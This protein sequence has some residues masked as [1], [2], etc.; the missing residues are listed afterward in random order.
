[1]Q[2]QQV[3]LTAYVYEEAHCKEANR[4][5]NNYWY[6]YVGEMFDEMGLRPSEISLIDLEN[7]ETLSAYKYII[8]GD[9]NLN[10]QSKQVLQRWVAAGGVLLGFVT[11]DADDL[12]GIKRIRTLKQPDD[13]FTV[14]AYYRFNAIDGINPDPHYSYEGAKLPIISD[15]EI[16]EVEG[17]ESLGTLFDAVQKNLGCEAIVKRSIGLGKTYYFTFDL[18]QTLWT[19]HQGRPVVRDIDGDGYYR[20]GDSLALGR[21]ISLEVP[22]ADYWLQFIE[23]VLTEIPQP[24][25]HQLPPFADGSVPDMLLHYGG[26]DECTPGIQVKASNY[27]KNKGLGYH[28]NIMPDKEGKFAIS[29]EEYRA[30]QNN[31]HSLSLHYD[32]ATPHNHFT[33][34]D[35]REQLDQYVAAFGEIPIAT[36][37]HYLT[38]TGWVEQARWASNYG[39]KGDNSRAHSFT[40]PYNPINLLGFGFGTVYP[41]FVYDDHEHGNRR[42]PYTYIPIALYEPRI[43]E[44]TRDEDVHRIQH[45]LD[46]ASHF[47]WTMNVFLHPI[48]IAGDGW[49]ENCLP[50]IEEILRYI[51]EKQ[52]KALHYST[53][54]LCLWWNERSET[55]IKNYAINHSDHGK[56]ESVSFTVQTASA[57]GIFVKMPVLAQIGEEPN[58]VI[59]GE[60]RSCV[61]RKQNGIDRAFC[62]IPEGR[63]QVEILYAASCKIEAQI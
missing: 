49:N 37:N 60:K 40:P 34:A 5:G 45:A 4:K 32:F 38:H 10:D 31:G 33:E 14:S 13:E 35:V 8:V 3:S 16:V 2:T 63:H 15:V 29:A 48:Y 21:I 6:K 56:V 53:D 11:K 25:V 36:V 26:D 17:G 19:M 59:D 12:F 30:I 57:N 7:D 51:G 43:Y 20:V 46:R 41:H 52:Y 18:L 23:R 58:Y 24:I 27:M 55:N 9:F 42:I 22:Y 61:I 54:Q 47:N 50:A 44:E 62:Y 28:M 1:M 39:V